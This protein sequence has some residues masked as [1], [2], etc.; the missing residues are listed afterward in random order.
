MIFKEIRTEQRT[1]GLVHS[2]C[3]FLHHRAGSSGLWSLR[4]LLS[5]PPCPA[6]AAWKRWVREEWSEQ[7]LLFCQGAFPGIGFTGS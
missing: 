1:S 6:C 3:I 5:A 4:C 2:G 7:W